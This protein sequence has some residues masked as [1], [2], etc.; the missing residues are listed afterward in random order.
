MGA[1]SQALIRLGGTAA[2]LALLALLAGGTAMAVVG[3]PGTAQVLEAI[4]RNP[5]PHLVGG[6]ALALVSLLDM[7]TVPAL[8]RVLLS[9]GPSLV[10]V[11]TGTALV[12][13]L[14][15]VLGRL[16]QTASVV[17]ASI[18]DPSGAISALSVLDVLDATLN[19]AG[20]L[21]VS[22]SFACFGLL[23]RRGFSR[24]LGTVA[25]G[26]GVCTFTG[27]FPGLAPLFYLANL[28]FL[29]WYLGLAVRFLRG[30]RRPS[31]PATSQA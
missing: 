4:G 10:T 27:Q 2:V 1:D 19:T 23:M 12:G 5:W 25:L 11:A 22:V 15:G 6:A 14:L 29:W 9:N 26:A 17:A 16:A 21:L 7:F 31:T 30:S 18:P 8:H 13:D 3:A 28:G 24:V 20:F